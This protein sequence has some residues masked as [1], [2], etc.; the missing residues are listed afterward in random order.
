M[1]AALG[2]GLSSGSGIGIRMG[3]SF[4]PTYTPYMGNYSGGPYSRHPGLDPFM[5]NPDPAYSGYPT[6][7]GSSPAYSGTSGTGYD[8]NAQP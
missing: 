7:S 3:P 2:F 5:T 1:A 8:P 6:N 4:G